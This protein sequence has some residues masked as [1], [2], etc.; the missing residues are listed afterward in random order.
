M[1]ASELCDS[2]RA[3]FFSEI[4]PFMRIEPMTVS[5]L[6]R[7]K[8]EF[9]TVRALL[10]TNTFHTAATIVERN[11][12]EFV[13]LNLT[14]SDKT[15]SVPFGRRAAIRFISCSGASAMTERVFKNSVNPFKL[16][17]RPA[18]DGCLGV[19]MLVWHSSEEAEEWV[20]RDFPNFY[21][22]LNDTAHLQDFKQIVSSVYGFIHNTRP[23]IK[24]R[25]VIKV[26]PH[27][28]NTGLFK[29]I[30]KAVK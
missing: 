14:D 3:D 13:L 17:V 6:E 1:N 2:I 9:L 12:F 30:R 11:F 7:M 10:F 19:L 27:L 22:F 28:E 24:R 8:A 4:L 18:I 15:F 5:Q 25:H 20:R 23:S 16:F 26:D 29:K 21:S